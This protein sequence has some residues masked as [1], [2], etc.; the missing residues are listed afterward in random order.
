MNKKIIIPLVLA[1]ALLVA[2][3]VFIFDNDI[4]DNGTNGQNIDQEMSLEENLEE[5]DLFQI[6]EDL[7]ALEDA[8]I[9]EEEL[10]EK[11]NDLED[12]Y[13]L[14]I[15]KYY[16]GEVSERELSR[17]VDNLIKDLNALEEEIINLSN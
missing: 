6:E 12:R 11:Y 5:M 13:F 4:E 2:G 9:I 10:I 7:L 16:E 17:K 14:I 15:D 1:L 8:G 3:F